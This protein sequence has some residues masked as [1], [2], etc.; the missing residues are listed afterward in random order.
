VCGT[1]LHSCVLFSDHLQLHQG[2]EGEPLFQSNLSPSLPDSQMPSI[3]MQ[4]QSHCQS[5]QRFFV[6]LLRPMNEAQDFTSV[7]H[8]LE[9]CKNAQVRLLF[10]C[11]DTSF[12]AQEKGRERK[13][14]HSSNTVQTHN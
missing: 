6:A 1:G 8:I 10:C 5:A 2:I 3:R 11:R 9:C 14:L 4:I 13:N 7:S 12:D